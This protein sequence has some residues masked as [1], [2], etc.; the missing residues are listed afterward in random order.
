MAN[1]MAAPSPAL[2]PVMKA[3]VP[4]RERESAIGTSLQ[5]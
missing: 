3:V 4:V 2:A 1:A 5:E